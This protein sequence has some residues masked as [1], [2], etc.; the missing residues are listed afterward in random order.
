MAKS[1]GLSQAKRP[2]T[3]ISS[4]NSPLKAAATRVGITSASPAR[5]TNASAVFDVA[6]RR[7]RP[8]AAHRA[9]SLPYKLRTGLNVNAIPLYHRGTP[10]GSPSG[11]R[12][13]DR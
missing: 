2:W 13:P 4:M 1:S 10:P 8:S 6:S 5:I 7:A 3:R 11:G 9:A 12:T